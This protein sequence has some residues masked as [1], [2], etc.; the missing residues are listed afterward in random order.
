MPQ[1]SR[2]RVGNSSISRLTNREVACWGLSV[3]LQVSLATSSRDPFQHRVIVEPVAASSGR[4]RRFVD[5][6]AY[7]CRQVFQKIAE[8]VA[9]LV[10]SFSARQT[11]F[12]FLSLCPSVPAL[13][14]AALSAAEMNLCFDRTYSAG[15]AYFPDPCSADPFY[16]DL[17][18]PDSACSAALC[19]YPDRPCSGRSC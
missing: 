15:P 4:Q 7:L 10:L 18:C 13:F 5:L 19:L 9:S 12:A 2:V 3:C 11:A 8:P 6:P 14:V 1:V 16:P 17:S